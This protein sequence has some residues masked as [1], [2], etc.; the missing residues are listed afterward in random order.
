M[1]EDLVDDWI[2]SVWLQQL[3]A[4]LCWQ[5]MLTSDCFRGQMTE[6]VK[7]QL[8]PQK[9]E[10]V[11]TL[12]SMTVKLQPLIIIKWQFKTHNECSYMECVQ[13]I[14]MVMRMVYLKMAMLTDK[15]AGGFSETGDLLHNI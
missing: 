2:K 3:D 9:C 14:H 12:G 15:C 13:K 10:L 11:I 6:N 4:L 1:T 8:R 7:V 5:T